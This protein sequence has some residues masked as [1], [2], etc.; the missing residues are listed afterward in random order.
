MKVTTQPNHKEA[1]KLVVN[2]FHTI[3]TKRRSKEMKIVHLSADGSTW[4]SHNSSYL[5]LIKKRARGEEITRK[6]LEG[7]KGVWLQGSIIEATNPPS[8]SKAEATSYLK[9]LEAEAKKEEAA[10]DKKR[11]KETKEAKIAR[12]KKE[13]AEATK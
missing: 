13:L 1:K 12:L 3:P 7:M 8:L 11:A 10:K 5:E 2:K 4:K 9:K 6:T